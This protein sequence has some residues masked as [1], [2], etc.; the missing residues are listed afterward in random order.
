MKAFR[1]FIRNIKNGIKSIT[2]NFSLS[3]A[4]IICTTITL[5]IVAIAAVFSANVD[6]FTK[7]LENTLT[8]MVFIDKNAS[9][10]DI[11]SIKSK[12]LEIKNIKSDELIYKTKE[13]IKNETI[14]G[15][16]K[17]D[18]NSSSL[19]VV[20]SHWTEEN[21]PLESEFILTVSHIEELDNT[22]ESLRTIDK[23]TNVKYS[24]D[25]VDKMIPTFD[26]VK[27]ITIGIIIGLVVVSI[28]LICNTIK[29]TIFARKSEI[30]I[31]RLV[32]TSNFVIKLPFV[33]EGLFL[34]VIGSIIPILC[35]IWGYIILYDKLDHHLFTNFIEMLE[36]MPF[37]IYISLL[38]LGV[39]GMVGMIGSYMT[40]RKYL[41]I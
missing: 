24:K 37:T 1:I 30:E 25:V 16:C 40:V 20:M 34:G 35:T 3:M 4:S 7:N 22:A 33:I 28:F 9:E 17:G 27:K 29:L 6:N 5:I 13:E 8:I 26:I 31:M 39:G 41:K 2:R 12:I 21:N 10:E 14:E 32:G 36:P 23:V 19:C 11:N 38:L 15:M 18:E